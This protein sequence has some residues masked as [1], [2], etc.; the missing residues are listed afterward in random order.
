[1]PI[2]TAGGL[3]VAYEREGAGAPLLLLMGLGASL[4]Y[5]PDGLLRAFADAGFDVVRMDN[6]DVGLSERMDHLGVP[7]LPTLIPRALA[8]MRTPVPYTL[9]DM[10]GDAV[11][12]L[13]ALGIDR[14]H[15][16]GASMGGMIAQTL[17]IGWPERV[18]SLTSVMSA[19]GA[20]RWLLGRPRAV[21]AVLGGRAATPEASVEQAVALFRAL[22]GGVHPFDEAWIRARTVQSI[23]RGPQSRAGL[24]RQ[25][26]AVVTAEDRT[27][28]LR[29]LAVPALVIHGT[30]DPLVRTGAGRA[31]ADA[32]PGA[33]FVALDGMGHELPAPVWTRIVDEVAALAF[34][35]QPAA[36]AV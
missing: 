1:M 9:R 17:A 3:R 26:A 34:R 27:P 28:H 36:H 24:A 13:D 33:R 8:G 14:A 5:W 20:R 15:V 11:A 22:S 19:P 30:H 16:L 25:L 32:I 18:A 35:H 21:S 7:H 29:R 2:I 6:R 23:A 12:L 31:T 4:L 10:A